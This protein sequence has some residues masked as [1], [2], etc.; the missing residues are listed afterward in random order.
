MGASHCG[1]VPLQ[2]VHATVPTGLGVPTD[3]G[4]IKL[5]G[6]D[7]LLVPHLL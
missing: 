7:P 1:K 3:V 2:M 6:V 5:D 4:V